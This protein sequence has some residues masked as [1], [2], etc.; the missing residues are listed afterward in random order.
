MTVV[1]KPIVQAA[2]PFLNE[3]DIK[4]ELRDCDTKMISEDTVCVCM[5]AYMQDQFVMLARKLVRDTQ[6]LSESMPA[7]DGK[8]GAAK[9]HSMN[10]RDSAITR[11]PIACKFRTF[12]ISRTR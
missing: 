2:N 11:L 5:P 8:T 7:L 6:E 10:S 3:V 4:P 12:C 9:L 1:Q